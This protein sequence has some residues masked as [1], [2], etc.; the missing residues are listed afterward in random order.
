MRLALH[1][2]L[3]LAVIHSHFHLLVVFYFFFVRLAQSAHALF[4]F[5]NLESPEVQIDFPHDL[6]ASIAAALFLK[7]LIG[8]HLDEIAAV[9]LGAWE[10]LDGLS[11]GRWRHEGGRVLVVSVEGLLGLLLLLINLLVHEL[12]E[13]CV[14]HVLQLPIF[15]CLAHEPV[16]YFLE[17]ILL[18][19][20]VGNIIG[21]RGLLVELGQ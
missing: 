4:A 1:L 14:R 19:L 7:R 2:P 5:I 10:S 9:Y 12:V 16:Q 15:V 13:I 11:V 3:A 20:L 6:D 8:C 21:E 18:S 17:G